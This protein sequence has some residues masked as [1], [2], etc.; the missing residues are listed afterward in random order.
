[1]KSE[2]TTANSRPC[3][4]FLLRSSY[5]DS[6]N[7]QYYIVETSNRVNLKYSRLINGRKKVHHSDSDN[8][9][10]LKLVERNL[11]LFLYNAQVFIILKPQCNFLS[12]RVETH[13]ISIS[14]SDDCNSNLVSLQLNSE[15]PM[16]GATPVMTRASPTSLLVLQWARSTRD[17]NQHRSCCQCRKMPAR[18]SDPSSVCP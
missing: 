11:D 17:T 10:W 12:S 2:Y 4:E 1:M 18:L 14:K 5:Y 13:W 8:F 7:T 3:S 16:S 9:N 6:R 15:M